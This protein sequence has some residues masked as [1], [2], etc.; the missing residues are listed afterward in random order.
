MGRH[1]R[2]LDPISGPVERFASELRM[3]RAIA[4][5][6]PFWKMA[7]RCGVSKSALAA[8]VAGREVPSERVTQEFVLACGG[9]W[10]WWRERRS[11]TVGELAAG[12]ALTANAVVL[13]VPQ[14]QALSVLAGEIVASSRP[15]DLSAGPPPATAGGPAKRSRRLGWVIAAAVAIVALV[16]TATLTGAWTP[17]KPS[18]SAPVAVAVTDGTDPEAVGCGSDKVVLDTS[19]VV[20]HQAAQ[21]RGRVLATGTRVGTVSLVYSAHCGGAWARFDPTP[22][23]NPDP[24]DNTDGITTIEADRP[25]DDTE[26]LWKMG[27]IDESY[28]GILLTGIGCVVAHARVDM[29]GQNVSATGQTRCLPNRR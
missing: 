20:L 15:R 8:A 27:H 25:A 12:S 23:L 28:S 14:A 10:S 29:A 6:L 9:D 1:M 21:V 13:A 2:P 24:N 5:D 22:G 16:G 19:P 4:G 17:S 7:R 3:L 11:Q 26:S 18:A